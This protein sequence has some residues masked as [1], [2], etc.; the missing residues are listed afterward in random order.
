ME[1]LFG[2]GEAIVK[3]KSTNRR[4]SGTGLKSVNSGSKSQLLG[5]ESMNNSIQVLCRFRP[6]KADFTKIFNIDTECNQVTYS[7]DYSDKKSFSFDKIYGV[8]TTQDEIF[9]KVENVIDS[10]LS[11]FNGTIL[12]YG[13]TNAGKSWTMEGLLDDSSELRG[14]IPRAIDRIFHLIEKSPENLQFQ[15]KLSYYEIY[16]EK[17]VHSSFDLIFFIIFILYHL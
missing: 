15:L 10:I 13:Q 2:A 17:Y 5:G 7:S 14:V 12:A 4:Q 11:G 1:S 6:S 9:A 8:D 3:M 16:C